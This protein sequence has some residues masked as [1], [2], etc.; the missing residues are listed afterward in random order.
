MDSRIDLSLS[1][2]VADTPFNF[3]APS[4]RQIGYLE[5]LLAFLSDHLRWHGLTLSSREWGELLVAAWR[6]EFPVPGITGGVAFIGGNYRSLTDE[7]CSEVITIA[8]EML[9]RVGLSPDT[10]P[11]QPLV[12]RQVGDC[13]DELS[14][15]ATSVE[16]RGPSS[17]GVR[18]R[19]SRAWGS[20]ERRPRLPGV[21]E[22]D[23]IANDANNDAEGE[24]R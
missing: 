24:E 3:R 15:V 13:L 20:I 19:S 14:V 23:Q 7:H 12:L 11:K 1:G 6:K 17:L 8:E 16:Q 5:S 9:S 10:P 21:F 18:L 2:M 4:L 22:P